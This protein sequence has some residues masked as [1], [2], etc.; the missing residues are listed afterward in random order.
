MKTWYLPYMA[1]VS[2]TGS[3]I[4]EGSV[5]SVWNYGKSDGVSQA[6]EYYYL[7]LKV[8]L[9][10]CFIVD[11][12][13]RIWHDCLFDRGFL[14]CGRKF[15]LSVSHMFLYAPRILVVPMFGYD[16]LPQCHD[17]SWDIF[18]SCIVCLLSCCILLLI[19]YFLSNTLGIFFA[20][21]KAKRM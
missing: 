13:S 20:R 14:V 6:M 2:G 1:G 19:I 18:L 11:R 4:S 5:C 10:H 9:S 15:G 7:F 8:L 3:G 12:W 21:K 16:L 17:A